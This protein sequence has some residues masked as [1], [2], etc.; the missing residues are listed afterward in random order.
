VQIDLMYEKGL[1]RRP[2]GG[3]S[4]DEVFFSFS[5]FTVLSV[6]PNN[7]PSNGKMVGK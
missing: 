6:S 2:P 1:D 7:I 3:K 4:H 5:Y